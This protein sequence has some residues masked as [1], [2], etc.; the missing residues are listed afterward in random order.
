MKTTRGLL[1]G[2]CLVAVLLMAGCCTDK[3]ASDSKNKSPRPWGGGPSKGSLPGNIN[4][5]R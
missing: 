1:M 5:G 4:E 2:L 3:P